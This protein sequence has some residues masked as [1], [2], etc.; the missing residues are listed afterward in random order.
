VYSFY[1]FFLD[2]I[3]TFL[4]A[5]WYTRASD[6]YFYAFETRSIAIDSNSEAEYGKETYDTG[7]EM[8][9]SPE[10]TNVFH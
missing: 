10:Y 1:I 2:Y 3:T 5:F 9:I 6:G 4:K 8:G 7:V